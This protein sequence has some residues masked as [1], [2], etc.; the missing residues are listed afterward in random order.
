M[1]CYTSHHI[2]NLAGPV[3]RL[4]DF[5]YRRYADDTQ[6]YFTFTLDN[7]SISVHLDIVGID[8]FKIWT[9]HVILMNIRKYVFLAA[10]ANFHL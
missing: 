10:L 6:L 3:I 7:P 1:S 5:S 2:C 9:M 4:Y 8:L